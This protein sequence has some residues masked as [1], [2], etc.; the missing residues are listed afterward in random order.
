[1]GGG[2]F[3][4]DAITAGVRFDRWTVVE[5]HEADL[6]DVA[7][8]RVHTRVGDGCAL[9]LPDDTYDTVLSIQ[10]LEHVFEPMQ[11]M[12]ELHRVAKPGG[13][14]VV[15]VPQTANLHHAPHHYQNLTRFWLEEAARRL[16][17]EVVEYHA[18]GGAW[19]TIAS[20]LVLQYPTAFGVSGYA[21]RDARRGWRFWALF[22]LG[23]V[24]TVVTF[25]FAMLL[26]AG[27][28]EEEANNHLMVLRKR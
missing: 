26:S 11:M 5:P 17:A 2:S 6:P 19:S 23:V 18:L 25:P 3:V 4:A 10:V 14:I 27:D 8:P 16:G 15:M 20:R 9:D 12:S 7:D 24:V 1:V 13:T 21:Y 28:L 22:P